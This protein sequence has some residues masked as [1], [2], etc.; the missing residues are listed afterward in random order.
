VKKLLK[1]YAMYYVL[2]L[3]LVSKKTKNSV[4][5]IMVDLNENTNVN[6]PLR[7]LLALIFAVAVSV[8]GYVNLTSRITQLEH[9][10]QITNVEVSMNSEFR[11][12][13]PRGELGA[14]P[15]DANQ[16]LRLNYIEKRLE[17]VDGLSRELEIEVHKAKVESEVI[18]N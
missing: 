17:M 10:R 5:I 16:D 13:W 9:S 14:L 18:D 1:N 12:K 7:N 4:I 11:V 6:I 2:F 8:T 15:A 3:M